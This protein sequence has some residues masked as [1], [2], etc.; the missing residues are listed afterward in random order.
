MGMQNQVVCLSRADRNFLPQMTRI[1]TKRKRS[2]FSKRW[3]MWGVVG[4]RGPPTTPHAPICWDDPYPPSSWRTLRR[5]TDRWLTVATLP[6][7]AILLQHPRFAF[8]EFAM[9]R[10]EGN[11]AIEYLDFFLS[12]NTVASR[13]VLVVVDRVDQEEGVLLG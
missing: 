9:D 4:G 12:H 7:H 10:H 3:G 1:F 13:K 6:L 2:I 5:M 11:F 8:V